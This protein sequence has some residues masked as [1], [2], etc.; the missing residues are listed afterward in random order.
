MSQRVLHVVASLVPQAGSLGVVL[1]GLFRALTA[2]G[3]EP[4]AAVLDGCCD[5]KAECPVRAGDKAEVHELVRQAELVHLHGCAEPGAALF[6]KAARRQGKPYVLAPLGAF[7]TSSPTRRSLTQ[8]LFGARSD[9]AMLRSSGR[10][11]AINKLE[12]A[13]LAGLVPTERIEIMPYG[14]DCALETGPTSIPNATGDP[15]DSLLMLGP[16]EPTEGAVVVL[17]AI[18]EVGPVAEGWH[19]VIA[20]PNRS[21]YRAMLEAGIHRKGGEGRVRFASASDT[22]EQRDRLAGASLLVAAGLRIRPPVSIMLAVSAG[23]PVLATDC[24]APDELV[25]HLFVCRPSRAELR[26]RLRE[27]L[28]LDQKKRSERA[29][30]AIEC[31]RARLDWRV[32]APRY[33]DFYRKVLQT[34]HR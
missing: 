2:E 33:A 14:V 6:A 5:V 32:L 22:D 20:G 28:E 24:V 25:E 3:W 23:V 29:T 30:G 21:N 18:A 16:I 27:V 17:K 12:A 19:V 1:P 8:R 4:S 9:K 15:H 11:Q 7:S 10:V 13:E 26:T 34:A 31:L